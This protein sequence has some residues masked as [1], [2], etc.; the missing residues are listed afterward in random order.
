MWVVFSPSLSLL[1]EASTSNARH[2][3][4]QTTTGKGGAQSKRAQRERET[5]NDTSSAPSISNM[6]SRQQVVHI[7]QNYR[8]SSIGRVCWWYNGDRKNGFCL[9]KCG[10]VVTAGRKC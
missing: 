8:F 1:S 7:V 9:S 2:G 6:C 10:Q 5:C 3:A 4:E